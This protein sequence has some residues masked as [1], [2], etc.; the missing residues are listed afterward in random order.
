MRLLSLATLG[1]ANQEIPY[2]LI[3]KTLQLDESEVETW[4]ITAMS[5]DVLDAKMD[6]LR[7]V[8]TIR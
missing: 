5:E 2:A 3:A 1:A 6:Q 7:R 4:V 8:V